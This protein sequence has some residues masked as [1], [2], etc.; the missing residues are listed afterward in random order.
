MCLTQDD[1][2]N[3]FLHRAD[4]RTR[5]ELDGRNSEVRRRT[6]FELIADRWNDPG[7]NSVAPPSDCHEDFISEINLAHTEVAMLN[8]AT[9]DKVEHAFTS[10]RCNLIRIIQNWERIGQGEGGHDGEQSDVEPGN[11]IDISR[12]FPQKLQTAWQLRPNLC[13]LEQ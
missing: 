10:M 11:T 13:F 3:A 7:F 1:I 6:A 4:A 5:Q 9:P 2:K 8:P 12:N